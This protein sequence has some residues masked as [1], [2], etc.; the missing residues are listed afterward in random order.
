MKR[1]K[2]LE[3][4]T[5]M[6][7]DQ[8]KKSV[9][10]ATKKSVGFAE[11]VDD[12]EKKNEPK[13]ESPYLPENKPKPI[14]KSSSTFVEPL[15][16]NIDIILPYYDK[17]ITLKDRKMIH[18]TQISKIKFLDEN[19]RLKSTNI[20]YFKKNLRKFYHCTGNCQKSSLAHPVAPCL[21]RSKNS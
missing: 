18:A 11:E 5:P 21:V 10:K 1:Q 9:P 4:R 14:L 17:C 8:K 15:Q 20:F 7:E 2:M 19:I 16:G 13:E 3:Q 6:S 12:E